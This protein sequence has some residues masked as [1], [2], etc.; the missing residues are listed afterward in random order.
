[1]GLS[2]G[3]LRLT[4]IKAIAMSRA[5]ANEFIHSTRTVRDGFDRASS[6]CA[7]QILRRQEWKAL[8]RS[9]RDCRR[10]THGCR[11][12]SVVDAR[13]GDINGCCAT[14]T[15][16]KLRNKSIKGCLYLLPLGEIRVPLFL[17]FDRRLLS[18]CGKRD[19]ASPIFDLLSPSLCDRKVR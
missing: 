6:S 4:N 11:W 16:G 9:C 3:T 14:Q 17:F 10:G 8:L 18:Q 12:E 5:S 19:L 13:L 1:V 2:L 7:Q 15:H